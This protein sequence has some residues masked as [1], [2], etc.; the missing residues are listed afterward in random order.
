MHFSG[1][2]FGREPSENLRLPTVIPISGLQLV[3]QGNPKRF[4]TIA[5]P[6]SKVTNSN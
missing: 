6:R 1:V 2:L 4:E 3:L 5:L